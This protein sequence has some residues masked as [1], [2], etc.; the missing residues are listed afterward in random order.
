MSERPRVLVIDEDPVLR[1]SLSLALPERGFEVS[2]AA[3]G[4][5]GKAD[6]VIFGLD[7]LD[8]AGLSVYRSL[9]GASGENVL[10]VLILSDRADARSRTE[11]RLLMG[12][13][14]DVCSRSASVEELAARLCVLLRYRALHL[15]LETEAGKWRGAP[16]AHRRVREADL[17]PDWAHLTRS[18]REAASLLGSRTRSETS[19]PVSRPL[20]STP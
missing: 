20:A 1:E 5:P 2:C 12:G 13:G 17:N 15:L 6:L 3:D 10:P 14:D 7:L 11:V 9:K 4:R 8:A 19:R 18:W 16:S